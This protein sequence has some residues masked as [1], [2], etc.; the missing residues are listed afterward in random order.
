M[1]HHVWYPSFRLPW[2]R[3]ILYARLR[4]IDIVM[5][6]HT[7]P[8][9]DQLLSIPYH[10]VLK[11]VKKAIA[12]NLFLFNNSFLSFLVLWYCSALALCVQ[13]KRFFH[14]GWW[15]HYFLH[16]LS[17]KLIAGPLWFQYSTQKCKLENGFLLGSTSLYR[18]DTQVVL[19]FWDY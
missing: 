17:K 18:L 5:K 4:L 15:H 19:P 8:K 6:L 12:Q 2:P 3:C 16:L 7:L 9:Y 14:K 11:D 10:K 13:C 1:Q